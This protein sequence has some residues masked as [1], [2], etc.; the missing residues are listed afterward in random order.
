[1]KKLTKYKKKIQRKNLKILENKYRVSNPK[2]KWAK[3]ESIKKSSFKQEKL[4][5][6][7]L[8]SLSKKRKSLKIRLYFLIK[9]MNKAIL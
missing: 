7:N 4:N 8:K 5:N 3:T 2:K 9:T 1:M 6:Q